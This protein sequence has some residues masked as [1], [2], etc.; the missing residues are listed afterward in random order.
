MP[1]FFQ[2]QR[3]ITPQ[4]VS[5]IDDS[6][7][8]N[9]NATS[10]AGVVA[11]IGRN[12]D[13]DS[14]GTPQ[15]PLV[16]N[17]PATAQRVLRNGLLLEGVLR[18]FAPGATGGAGQVVALRVNTATQSAG[19]LVDITA[20]TPLPAIALTSRDYGAYT[21]RTT[22][23]VAAPSSGT[24]KNLTVRLDEFRVDGF[25]I[26]YGALKIQYTGSGSAATATVSY[27]A[28]QPGQLATSITGAAPDNVLLTFDAYPTLDSLVK[29]LNDTGKY[30][31]S[32]TF[33]SSAVV[34]T[35]ASDG[36]PVSFRD[37][38][39][40]STYLDAQTSAD[41]KAT[42]VVLRADVQAATDWLNSTSGAFVVATRTIG[43][44]VLANTTIP[45]TLT[46]GLNYSSASGGVVRTQDWQACLTALQNVDAHLIVPL[47]PEP[48]VHA[49]VQAHVNLMSTIQQGYGR[50]ERMGIVGGDWGETPLSATNAATR[51]ASFQDS[52][53]V[54]VAPGIKDYSPLTG[55]LRNVPPY[56][57]AAQIAG[58]I[59]GLGVSE[60][61]TRR[62]LRTS[63]IEQ[64]SQFVGSQLTQAERE[65]WNLSGVTV[66][67]QIPNR[68][69]R[70]VQGLT[71]WTGDFNYVKREISVRRAA[72]WI[73]RTVRESCD[74]L[75]VGQSGSPGL[76]RRAV[77]AVNSVLTRLERDGVIVGDSNSPA[78]K[79]IV[80]KIEG[81]VLRIDFEC[82]PAIPA[83]YV[84][85]TAHMIP[86]TGTLTQQ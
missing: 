3:I 84:L 59:G 56:L 69:V 2:G 43:T 1:V 54:V 34:N 48:A 57:L 39:V 74:E 81:D 17:D 83:N 19:T 9:E 16:F 14:G 32:I 49:M 21:A 29:A 65:L 33:S 20:V 31:A 78:F 44:T 76:L 22:V 85:I 10:P 50:R 80:A 72:D 67:E 45:L 62:Y 63:G 28:G 86:Y 70:V 79:N 5:F 26:G 18:A 13:A 8:V 38:P 7:M 52:R 12:D 15:Q 71:S 40:A 46:G 68:G 41:I 6:A 75:L 60:A 64:A 36:L 25:N 42:S 4:A 77:V 82:S 53:M 58:I 23:T 61:I 47:T 27:P 73:A 11:I 30:T 24:G 51:A 66:L 37:S 55:L 35:N